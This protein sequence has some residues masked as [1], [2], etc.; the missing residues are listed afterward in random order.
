MFHDDL[1]TIH[2]AMALLRYRSRST[3]DAM[4]EKRRLAT[5]QE[6]K[7]AAVPAEYRWSRAVYFRRSEIEAW[8]MEKAQ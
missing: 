3:I 6:E 4:R 2:E 7:D 5:T 1:I 8:Q